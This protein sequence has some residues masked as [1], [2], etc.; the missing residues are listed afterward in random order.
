MATTFPL[1]SIIIPAYNRAALV[2]ETLDSILVQ[3]YTNWECLVVDDHSTDETLEVLNKYSEID[4]RVKVYKRPSTTLKGACSCR[5]YGFEKSRG[6]YVVYFDSDDIMCKDYIYK[7]YENCLNNN[8]LFSI[9]KFS[10]FNNNGKILVKE[11]KLYH[12]NLLEDFIIKRIKVNTPT[13]FLHRDVIKEIPYDE[14]LMKAQD[15]DFIYRVFLN[16]AAA[17]CILNEVLVKVRIHDNRITASYKNF[18]L[19]PLLSSIEVKWRILKDTK[20]TVDSQ[21]FLEVKNIFISELKLILFRGHFNTFYQ[22]LNKALVKGYLSKKEYLLICGKYGF[23]S[24]YKI[25][26]G[27]LKRSNTLKLVRRKVTNMLKNDS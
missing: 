23:Q 1:V 19:Q 10:T 26:K 4:K 7:Q 20:G 8:A 2:K 18:D 15:L 24:L 25:P 3:T 9:C 16:F 27:I 6:Q 17:G 5:N 14:T 13:L 22:Y 11:S 12:K 21:I